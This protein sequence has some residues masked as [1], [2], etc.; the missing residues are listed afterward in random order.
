MF[1]EMIDKVIQKL[2]RSGY[3]VARA[4]K[5]T[6]LLLILSEKVFQILRGA[7]KRIFLKQ[8][9]GIFFLGRKA[10]LKHKNKIK[11][12]RSVFIGD[13]VEINALSKDG[14]NI[15]NNVSLHRGTIIDCTGGIRDIGEG[16]E[17]G[18]SVGFSPNCYI[19]VRGRVRIGDNVIFG[20]NA[21]VFSENHNFNDPTK[22]INEQGETRKGVEIYSGVWVGTS[23]IILDGVTVGKNSIIAAG[24]VV[25]KDV[26]ENSIVGGIPAKVIKYRT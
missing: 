10:T 16:I 22:T 5:F 2:G 9:H 8:C 17:I 23:A 1:I 7:F 20:P 6:N 19:Q 15:G 11:L 25:N 4:I 26:P 24:S 12:G 18:N 14:V 21:K 13:F 3:K